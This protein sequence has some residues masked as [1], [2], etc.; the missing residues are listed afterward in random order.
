MID[1]VGG[2]RASI[3]DLDVLNLAQAAYS[4]IKRW[5]WERAET[6]H[7]ES[8]HNYDTDPQGSMGGVRCGAGNAYF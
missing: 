4:K 5:L 3:A 1:Q 7:N 8:E 6:Y 2:L